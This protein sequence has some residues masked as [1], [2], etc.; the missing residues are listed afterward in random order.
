VFASLSRRKINGNES[1]WHVVN[2]VPRRERF[3][4]KE[5]RCR[6]DNAKEGVTVRDHRTQRRME[7][8]GVNERESLYGQAKGVE[9]SVRNV[10]GTEKS[11]MEGEWCDTERK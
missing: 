9:W 6:C 3:K 10:R 4:W 8:V 7:Y 5:T 1:E 2:N 11:Q